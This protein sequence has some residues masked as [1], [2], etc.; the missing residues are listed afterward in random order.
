MLLPATDDREATH[1]HDH[2]AFLLDTAQ[3]NTTL[4]AVLQSACALA[5]FRVITNLTQPTAIKKT[6]TTPE[7]ASL[8]CGP[9]KTTE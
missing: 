9:L 5:V 7:A 6:L 8:K 1:Y 4:L 3:V 2:L